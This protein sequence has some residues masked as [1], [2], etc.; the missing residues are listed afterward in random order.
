M[1]NLTKVF[2]LLFVGQFCM[3]QQ[4]L[5]ELSSKYSVP[6][7]KEIKKEPLVYRVHEVSFEK[8]ITADRVPILNK[9][10]AFLEKN[11]KILEKDSVYY[12]YQLEVATKRQDDLLKI[13]SLIN[14][15][16]V[17]SEDFEIKKE[18]LI[19]AQLLSDKNNLTELIYADSEIN[20]KKSDDFFVLQLDEEYF[21]THLKRIIWHIEDSFTAL[22]T[23]NVSIVDKNLQKL[24]LALKGVEKY[25]YSTG[26]NKNLIRDG[27]VINKDFDNSD[28]LRGDFE[29]LGKHYIL[30]NGYKDKFQKEEL[31]DHNTAIKNKLIGMNYSGGSWE[32]FK[33]K[34]TGDLY[35]I[36]FNFVD[37][38]AFIDGKLNKDKLPLGAYNGDGAVVMSE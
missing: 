13:K 8:T 37:E 36:D 4:N 31:I 5:G 19:S 35:L 38:H 10:Y 26:V 3:G 7:K 12:N 2:C 32:L 33:Q 11:I 16:I 17:S 34:N 24:R 22:P 29:Q 20:S 23:T 15:F 30:Y 28:F 27:F 6:I 21:K 25:K 18:K 1:K 9:E 14:D